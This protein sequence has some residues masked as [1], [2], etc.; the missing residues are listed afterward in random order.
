MLLLKTSKSTGPFESYQIELT[1]GLESSDYNRL[2]AS[3]GCIL[4]VLLLILSALCNLLQNFHF[5]R[6]IFFGIQWSQL[7]RHSWF[8]SHL[9]LHSR[10]DTPWSSLQHH[11]VPASPYGSPEPGFLC[12]CFHTFEQKKSSLTHKALKEM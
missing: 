10:G 5:M 12:M 7:I 8:F 4:K 11:S 9:E 3:F 1:I 2:F 6:Q